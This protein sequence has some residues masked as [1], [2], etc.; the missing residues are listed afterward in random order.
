MPSKNQTIYLVITNNGDGSNGLQWIDDSKVLARMQKL[1]DEGDETYGSG[2]GLQVKRLTFPAE[3]N[4]TAWL[5]S[6][7][8]YLTTWDDDGLEFRLKPEPDK[9]SYCSKCGLLKKQEGL[10][11]HNSIVCDGVISTFYKNDAISVT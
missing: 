6:N 1:A 3:V 10:T 9:V 11:P 8:L 7:G 2:D 5:A 4:V